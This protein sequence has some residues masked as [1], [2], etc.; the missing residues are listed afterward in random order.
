MINILHSMIFD[1]RASVVQKSFPPAH[2]SLQT[3]QH[4]SSTLNWITL[5]CFAQFLINKLKSN[6]SLIYPLRYA[7]QTSVLEVT[8]YIRSLLSR[9][10][11]VR[12]MFWRVCKLFFGRKQTTCASINQVWLHMIPARE[13]SFLRIAVRVRPRFCEIPIEIN[14]HQET[15]EYF[16]CGRR[17]F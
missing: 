12:P 3:E 5:H 4:S 9:L 14:S 15:T 1:T 8:F 6:L 13:I 11:A 17:I 10:S 16:F 2:T 7:H